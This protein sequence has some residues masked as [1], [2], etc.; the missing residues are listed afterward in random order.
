MNWIRIGDAAEVSGFSR[1][2]IRN[3]VDG[4]ILPMKKIRGLLYVD[5]D[6]LMKVLDTAGDVDSTRSKLEALKETY[7]KEYHEY[8]K[9]LACQRDSVDTNRYLSICVNAGIRNRFFQNVVHMLEAIGILKYREGEM[10]SKLLEGEDM[11]EIC[12]H[13]GLN[14]E[15]VRQII[16]TAIRKSSDVTSIADIVSE[17]KKLSEQNAALQAEVAALRSKLQIVEADVPAEEKKELD[18]LRVVL[19]K[20]IIDCPI[21]VRA[22]NILKAYRVGSE[23]KNI[24]TLGD[25]CRI[26]K[27]DY[28]KQRNAGKKSLTELENLLE[29]YGLEFGMDVDNIYLK[30]IAN[31]K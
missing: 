24:E 10:L 15:R 14:R 5:K 8:K 21:S 9:L 1:Q 13:Y 25:L 19:A 4:K 16:E 7:L 29:S 27:L 31:K 2:T 20:K 26:N 12:N 17:N 22:I 28:L 6:V 3:W 18:R 23:F 11:M 30:G